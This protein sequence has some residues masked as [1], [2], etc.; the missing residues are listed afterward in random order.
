MLLKIGSLNVIKI[1]CA[2][3]AMNVSVTIIFTKLSVNVSN[4]IS[5]DTKKDNMTI[6]IILKKA[7]IFVLL[8][9]KNVDTTEKI[10]NKAKNATVKSNFSNL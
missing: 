5:L 1:R 3:T 7:L 6:I 4:S 10:I 2:Q 8:K 9:L